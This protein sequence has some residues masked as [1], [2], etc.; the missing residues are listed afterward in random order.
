MLFSE[1]VV[2]SGSVVLHLMMPFNLFFFFK[3]WE[4]FKGQN[5]VLETSLCDTM[6]QVIIRCHNFFYCS[7]L[8]IAVLGIWNCWRISWKN[9]LRIN[10]KIKLRV[11]CSFYCR[12]LSTKF[13]AF[14]LTRCNDWMITTHRMLAGIAH[15]LLE[16]FLPSKWEWFCSYPGSILWLLKFAPSV[17][18]V[19]SE[20]KVF[21]EEQKFVWIFIILSRVPYNLVLWP[22]GLNVFTRGLHWARYFNNS[23]RQPQTV[24]YEQYHV[25]FW[26]IGLKFAIILLPDCR[27]VRIQFESQQKLR[28]SSTSFPCRNWDRT[29]GTRLTC[30]DKKQSLCIL[31]WKL[32]WLSD[33]PVLRTGTSDNHGWPEK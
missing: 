8:F 17:E 6:E 2:V 14:H 21:S 19:R 3:N 25:T 4:D 7:L 24:M 18:L 33:V 10:S 32:S 1:W 29:L 26:Q 27:P 13:I 31:S 5:Y 20:K 12:V 28:F 22:S 23:R 9:N 15:K 11:Y 16:V 30:Q